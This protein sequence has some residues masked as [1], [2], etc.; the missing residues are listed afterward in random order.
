MY[1]VQRSLEKVAI[2]VHLVSSITLHF[3]DCLH[4]HVLCCV[5]LLC[6]VL[7]F[8]LSFSLS[9]RR[10]IHVQCTCVRHLVRS[11]VSLVV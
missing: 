4:V 6:V 2:L 3:F 1:N 7:P 11:L 9:E 10:N 5:V 8:F